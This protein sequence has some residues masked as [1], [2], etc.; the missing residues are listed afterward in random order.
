M[1]LISLYKRLLHFC[2]SEKIDL[3]ET[4]KLPPN[5]LQEF[6]ER[7]KIR[8]SCQCGEMG[9]RRVF[10]LASGTPTRRYICNV[11]MKYHCNTC[12]ENSQELHLGKCKYCRM[13]YFYDLE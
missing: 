7:K 12:G 6:N 8:R 10:I 5:I 3:S 13:V 1:M 2:I 11:C 9:I 4:D